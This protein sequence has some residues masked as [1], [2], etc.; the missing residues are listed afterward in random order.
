MVLVNDLDKDL[1]IK[2][3]IVGDAHVYDSLLGIK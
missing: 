1:V 2:G 3:S